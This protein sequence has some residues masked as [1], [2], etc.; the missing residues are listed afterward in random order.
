MKKEIIIGVIIGLVA[1]LIIG[2]LVF[3]KS[4]LEVP[5]K[6]VLQEMTGITIWSIAETFE[7]VKIK[8]FGIDGLKDNVLY[9]GC[10]ESI[11][12]N[13][14]VYVGFCELALTEKLDI[15][16]ENFDFYTCRLDGVHRDDNTKSLLG[17]CKCFYKLR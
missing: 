12:G 8:E 3:Y 5:N 2:G 15:P 17:N 10:V 9:T 14:A 7:G 13:Q 4:A 1:G 16:I 6:E 11:C